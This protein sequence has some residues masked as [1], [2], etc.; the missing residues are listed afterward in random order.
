MYENKTPRDVDNCIK[1]LDTSTS[2]SHKY[3]LTW[4]RNQ[5]SVP[6]SFKNHLIIESGILMKPVNSVFLQLHKSHSMHHCITY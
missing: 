4:Y 3:V 1:C 5:Q 2:W 6:K